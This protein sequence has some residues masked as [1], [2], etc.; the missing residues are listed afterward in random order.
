MT[1]SF[2][3]ISFIIK[4]GNPTEVTP[5]MT[6]IIC[7]YGAVLVM[8]TMGGFFFYFVT[9]NISS[10]TFKAGLFLMFGSLIFFASDN[11]LA[12]GK[13]NTKYPITPFW[14]S[15]LIMITYYVAQW[16]IAKGTFFICIYW[17]EEK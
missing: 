7:I 11:F 17:V 16:M 3:S 15:F 2:W 14:N 6:V 1:F 9:S 10:Y 5:L 8:L 12:H 4:Y 13:F